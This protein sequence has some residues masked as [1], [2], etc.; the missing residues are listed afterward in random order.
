MFGRQKIAILVAE[1]IGTGVLAT[2]VLSMIGRTS[3]PF[4]AAV[5]VGVTVGTMSYLFGTHSNPAVTVGLWTMKK[6]KTTQA[7]VLIV[8]QMLGGLGAWRLNEYLLNS[9]LKSMAGETF[10]WRVLLAE[11]LGAFIVGVAIAA[12]V[13]KGYDGAKR[14]VVTG[15]AFFLGVNVASMASNGLLNPAVALGVQSWSWAYTLGPVLGAIIG[16][17]FYGLL[18]VDRPA[19]VS[20]SKVSARSRKSVKKPAK[21]VSRKR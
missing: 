7:V 14:A 20:K 4:F 5:A 6:V 17:S 9:D 1:F 15:L 12:A 2:V 10:D 18:F 8:A 13:S 19:R 16:M 3:F 11:A 21:K